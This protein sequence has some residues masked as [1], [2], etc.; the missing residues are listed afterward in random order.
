LEKLIESYGSPKLIKIDVEGFEYEALKTLKTHPRYII[1]EVTFSILE[2]AKKCI[3]QLESLGYK[4]FNFLKEVLHSFYFKKM[5]YP[6]Q[7]KKELDNIKEEAVF[8]DIY[9]EY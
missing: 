6:E 1:F 8:G 7:L 5:L 4:K 9:A 3:D 2:T